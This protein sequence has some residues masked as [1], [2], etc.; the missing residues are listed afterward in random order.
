[1]FNHVKHFLYRCVC[2]GIGGRGGGVGS[3]LCVEGMVVGKKPQDGQ[4]F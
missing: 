4:G 1:M 2:V 3:S